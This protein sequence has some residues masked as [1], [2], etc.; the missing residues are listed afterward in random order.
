MSSQYLDPYTSIF[1]TDSQTICTVKTS[2]SQYQRMW[3]C[4][5]P[6]ASPLRSGGQEENWMTEFGIG[7]T[8]WIPG[9][10]STRLLLRL[11][12]LTKCRCKRKIGWMQGVTHHYCSTKY[13]KWVSTNMLLLFLWK[14][15]WCPITNLYHYYRRLCYF[16]FKSDYTLHTNMGCYHIFMPW[17]TFCVKRVLESSAAKISLFTFMSSH[18]KFSYSE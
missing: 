4:P 11:P 13:V 12:Q 14:L 5:Q 2:M 8:V 9:L 15:K 3:I 10:Y 6:L 17:Y 16:I 7:L 18:I 1:I